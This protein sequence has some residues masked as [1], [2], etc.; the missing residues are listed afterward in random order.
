MSFLLDTDIII[1]LLNDTFPSIRSK[2][3]DI[4]SD[5]IH[6]SSITVAELHFGA[7]YSSQVENNIELL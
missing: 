1:Y 4:S 3:D 2:I 6:I 7:F 5:E